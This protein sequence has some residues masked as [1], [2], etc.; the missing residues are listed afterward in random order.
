[1]D[2]VSGKCP[3]NDFDPCPASSSPHRL[4]NYLPFVDSK[5]VSGKGILC[6]LKEV[7]VP[8][9][10]CLSYLQASNIHSSKRR[11]SYLVYQDR[12]QLFPVVS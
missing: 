10:L 6:E 3:Y 12:I 8:Y 11:I 5:C 4:G 1:M 9:S 2:K 7:R